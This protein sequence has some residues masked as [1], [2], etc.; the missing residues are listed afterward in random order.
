LQEID[1]RRRGFLWAGKDKAAGGQCMVAWPSV[2]R[3]PDFGGL[4]IPD[5][6]NRRPW[7][8]LELD[9]GVNHAMQKMF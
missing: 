4:G 6:R 9:F 8:E 2:C 5:Q 3:L 7:R 1:K